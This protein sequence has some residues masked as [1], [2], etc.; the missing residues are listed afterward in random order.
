MNY[1]SLTLKIADAVTEIIKFTV[2]V[3]HSDFAMRSHAENVLFRNM[4]R[5][6]Y[7]LGFL[8]S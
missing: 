1:S 8:S 5:M 7:S 4:I 2:S 6:F 3:V